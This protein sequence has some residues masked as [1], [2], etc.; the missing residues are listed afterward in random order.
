MK[1]KPKTYFLKHIQTDRRS[2]SAFGTPN[3]VHI[4]SFFAESSKYNCVFKY[5]IRVE[6]FQDT[7][8]IK[9]YCTRNKHSEYKYSRVLN[10]FS[11]TEVK[12]IMEIAASV[13]PLILAADHKASFVFNGSRTCDEYDYIEGPRCTQRFRIYMEIVR[14][15]FGEEVFYITYF[16]DSS[17]CIF[18]NRSANPDI[19]KAKI[20]IYNMFANIFEI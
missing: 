2:A 9:Y 10:F 5:I 15:L 7:Y 8:A 14:R 12:K 6:K 19:N 11:C 3:Q 17:S 16:N 18:V 20:R 1:P 4:Y 13:I